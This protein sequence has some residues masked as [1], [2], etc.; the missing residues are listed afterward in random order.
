MTKS[1]ATYQQLQLILAEGGCPICFLGQQAA[2]A[3]LD[4]LLWESVNDSGI[5]ESLVASLGFCGRHSRELLTFS[6]ERVGVAI[7]QRA[8]L[9]AAVKRVEQSAAAQPTL[10]QRFQDKF[11][12]P[13]HSSSEAGPSPVPQS[14]P[15]C[16]HQDQVEGRGL[17]TLL[18]HLI[19]DLDEPLR[20]AGGLCWPHLQQA[21]HNS[22][23]QRVHDV[24]VQLHR[25]VWED[26]IAQLGEFV[27]KNDHRFHAE[28]ITAPE[29]AAVDRS[30]EI[31]T[32]EYLR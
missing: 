18:S 31:L 29:R 9:Q 17:E 4:N 15:A 30:I 8:I 24:L 13:D 7:L 11:A 32:G 1:S 20:A 6:G 2:R 28:T 21:L 27:R 16:I 25:Q 19:G 26:I 14:C 23:D 5:R 12:G 3:Y 22:R 10:V